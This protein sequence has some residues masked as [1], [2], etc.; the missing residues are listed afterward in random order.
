MVDGVAS[1]L[2]RNVRRRLVG[3]GQPTREGVVG[4]VEALRVLE[5]DGSGRLRGY[6]GNGFVEGAQRVEEDVAAVDDDFNV[7]GFPV[8]LGRAAVY[9]RRWRRVR[10]A[11]VTTSFERRH[12]G[13]N[14]PDCSGLVVVGGG[15]ARQLSYDR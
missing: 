3:D 8:G 12:R 10:R 14:K 15:D 7:P 13:E 4:D 11:A 1:R 6:R 5:D 2:R 9:R